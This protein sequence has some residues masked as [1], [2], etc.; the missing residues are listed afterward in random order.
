MRSKRILIAYHDPLSARSLSNFLFNSGHIIEMAKGVS[1]AIRMVREG[2]IY[3]ILL[4]EEIEGVKACDLIPLLKGKSKEV[5]VIAVT[6]E[7]SIEGARPLLGAGI[8]YHAVKPV[9]SE[10]IRSAVDCAF[11]KIERENIKEDL[12]PYSEW[13]TA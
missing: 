13:V 8:F 10:E 9:D 4:D 12:F 11:E 5:Q 2:H 6:S 7:E 1:E 3:V